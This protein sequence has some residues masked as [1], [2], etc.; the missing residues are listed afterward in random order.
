M[1]ECIERKLTYLAVPYAHKDPDVKVYRFNGVNKLASYLMKRGKKVFSPISHCHPIETIASLNWK[2]HQFIEFDKIY[3]GY[4]KELVVF[5][6][7]EWEKSKGVYEEITIA[8]AYGIPVWFI[9]SSWKEEIKQY[10]EIQPI[11]GDENYKQLSF[12]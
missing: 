1:N 3:L 12:F 2:H 7:D 11:T 10:G 9:N 6:L 5:K 8:G 4:S